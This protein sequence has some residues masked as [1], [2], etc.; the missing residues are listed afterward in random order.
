MR[1]CGSPKTLEKRRRKALA[2]LKKGLSLSQVATLV[3]A[4]VPSVFRWKQAYGRGGEQALAAKAVSGRPRKLAPK[5]CKR[6]VKILLSGALASGFPND[7]WTLRRIAQVIE[8]EFRVEYHP[9]HLWRV[10]QRLGWSCQVPERR[11]I[12]RDEEAIE[13]WKRHRWPEIKKTARTWCPPG[14]SRR[15]RVSPHPDKE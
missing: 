11:A 10:L 6:L 4:S 12:Q 5:E 9:S 1:P 8:K 7:V 14:F 3:G 2:L 15:K 13:F